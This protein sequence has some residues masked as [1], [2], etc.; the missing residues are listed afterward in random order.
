MQE[1]EKVKLWKNYKYVRDPA[2]KDKITEF[3]NLLI[4]EI[5]AST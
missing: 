3:L 2:M 4:Q 1:V 5:S